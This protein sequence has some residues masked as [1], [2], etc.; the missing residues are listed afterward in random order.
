VGRAWGEAVH[1]IEVARRRGEDVPGREAILLD[2]AVW[3]EKWGRY[4]GRLWINGSAPDVD[5]KILAPQPIERDIGPHRR[6][7]A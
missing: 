1:H 2:P 6:A 4:D 5:F 3:A 7:G